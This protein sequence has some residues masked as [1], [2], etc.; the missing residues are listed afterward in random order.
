MSP[1]FIFILSNFSS[2]IIWLGIPFGFLLW[3][4]NKA[5]SWVK[6]LT[7]WLTISL[8]T[9]FL[10]HLARMMGMNPNLVHAFYG[11]L[12]LI[13]VFF[14][15]QRLFNNRPR[16]AVVIVVLVFLLTAAV[17]NL[18]IGQGTNINSYSFTAQAFIYSVLAVV[19]FF[20]LLQHPPV[21]MI[22]R[23]PPFWFNVGMMVYFSG[24]LILFTLTH[25]LVHQLKNDLMIY[26]TFH[27]VLFLFGTGFMCLS[28]WMEYRLQ[29]SR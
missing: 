16:T 17:L 24:N 8:V 22:Q 6:L 9:F 18:V 11:M 2:Q 5:D 1:E 28:L 12:E 27:N 23:F 19:Y 13:F 10:S 7:A 4:S 14:I 3:R 25:Y 26:W 21:V 29:K 20:Y 15:Y